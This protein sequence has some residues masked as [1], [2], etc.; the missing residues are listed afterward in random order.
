MAE[1]QYSDETFPLALIFPGQGSQHVGMAQALAA[2]FPVA[3]QTLQEAD[4]ILAFSLSTLCAEGP[5]EALTATINAQP[6]LLAA[7][8]ATLRVLQSEMGTMPRPL[9]FAGHSLGEYSALVAANSISFADG[10]RLVR[11]RG[12]LM[13]EAGQVAPGRMAAVLGLDEDVVAQA[14]ADAAATSSGLVQIAND[15]CPGQIVISG[16]ATAMEAAMAALQAAGARKVVPLDV[17]I[18]SHSPLMAPVAG[19]LRAAIEATA[20]QPPIAPLLANTST[21]AITEPAAIVDELAAQLTGSVKWTGSMQRAV[22]AGVTV[23]AEIGPGNVLT[24][25]IKRIA[26]DA[27]RINVADAVGVDA[28]RKSVMSNNSIS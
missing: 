9:F 25:L 27:E 2:Q 3:R 5:A 23:F 21:D 10:L 20:I 24:G 16:D 4:D 12:R 15:N 11:E 19:Q 8:I 28:F 7:S 14:C 26:R 22:D 17:S 18:A 6:A 13:T 1:F